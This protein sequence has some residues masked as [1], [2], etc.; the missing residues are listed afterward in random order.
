M[1]KILLTGGAGY[2]GAHIAVSLVHSGFQPIIIDNFSNSD[3]EIL[4]GIN[5]L[6]EREI[7]FYNLDGRDYNALMG[8]VNNAGPIKAVI[9]LAAF[10][11][12]GESVQNPLKYFD[13]NLGSM[14]TMLRVMHD[15]AIPNLVFSSSCTV[16]GSPDEQEV[17]EETPFG[18]AYSPYGYTKQ[19]CERMMIDM[20]KAYPL[21]K[22]VS[23]RYF[24]PI[25]AH[26]TAVI[27]EWPI[28]VPNNL[29]PFI[30]QA[31]AN[32]RARLTVFGRD[33]DTPDGTCVRD[34]IHVCDLADA[35]VSAL[36]WML[37]QEA[38][39]LENFNIGTGKGVSVKE[40]IDNFQAENGVEV[41]FEYGPRRPGDV[42]AIFANADKANKVLGWQARYTF[43][44][45]LKHA[46]KWEQRLG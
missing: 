2:I 12:V 15:S 20:S 41:P 35:H 38:P 3:I 13:N 19:A 18:E 40:I 6:C 7:P 34:Y 8:V 33:Y 45:A 4:T 27:G 21:M 9:H 37:E 16:Y 44:D 11:A 26:P 36:R 14:Y 31:A 29:V 1:D 39:L 10:K 43:K 24:N 25:G 28:G 17:T 32:K 46:W 42:P 22:Q 5:A 23:L 30:T